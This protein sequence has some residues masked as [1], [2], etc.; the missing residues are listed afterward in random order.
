[1]RLSVES[2]WSH[3]I[4]HE[5]NQSHNNISDFLEPMSLNAEIDKLPQGSDRIEANKNLVKSDEVI[6]VLKSIFTFNF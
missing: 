1:M 3:I 4:D 6:Y 2:P 5:Q